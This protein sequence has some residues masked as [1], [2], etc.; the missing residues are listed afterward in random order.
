[1]FSSLTGQRCTTWLD[2]S[3]GGSSS[4]NSSVASQFNSLFKSSFAVGSR[5]TD[6][7]ALQ[8]F[9]KDEGYYFGRVDGKYG[10]ITD[11]AVKDFQDDN[12]ITVIDR[13][14]PITVDSPVI[15]GV[16][17]PQ[18]LNVNQ[19]GTWSVS[20][21]DSNG[22]NLTYAVNWGD[23]YSTDILRGNSV[24]QPPS[25]S[26]TFTH[27]YANTG[28]Y[29]VGFTVTNGNDQSTQTTLSVNVGGSSTQCGLT[30]EVI[31]TY[32]AENNTSW[33]FYVKV[34]NANPPIGS[35]GW[36]TEFQGYTPEVTSY[37]ATKL[38]GNFF[39]S[40]GPLQFTPRDQINS[41]CS[42]TIYVHPPKSVTSSI[43]V[44]SPNGG[45]TFTKNM[46]YKVF[47]TTTNIPSTNNV[48]VRL[49]SI[50]TGQESLTDNVPNTG[51]SGINIP[52]DF[53]DGKYKLEVKT[54][55]NGVSYMD[56]SD[57]SFLITSTTTQ[58]SITVLSPNGGEVWIK[59]TTQTIKWQ[60]NT[61]TPCPGVN[62][63]LVCVIAPP[64][65]D[66]SLNGT[67]SCSGGICTT[68]F[69]V[70]TIA[71]GVDGSSYVWSVGKIIAGQELSQI[72]PDGSYRIQVCKTGTDTCD[73]S[74]SYFTITSGVPTPLSISVLSP[75]GGSS[76]WT[77]NWTVDKASDGT[78]IPD[79]SDYKLQALLTSGWNTLAQDESDAYFSITTQSSNL[80]ITTASS[81]PNGRVGQDYSAD[82]DGSGDVG[83]YNWGFSNFAPG[84]LPPGLS[85]GGGL[86]NGL[87]QYGIAGVPTTVGTY[88]FT[89]ILTSKNMST[90]QQFT[91]T[92]DPALTS[93]LNNLNLS[94]S[95]S[96]ALL[97]AGCTVTS[98]YSITTGKPCR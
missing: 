56:A 82:I 30:A 10:R 71:I 86:R 29:K 39:L 32:L 5:G 18:S 53:A 20:A 79:G 66:I 8:Q 26:A 4:D 19:Q 62:R 95:A 41:N 40:S 49:R 75:N 34:N 46:Q 11:R 48:T 14:I 65:Y 72:V 98:A 70:Y 15:S 68:G 57:D 92:I 73:S 83:P 31:K 81:L 87:P 35:S 58:P 76:Q 22:G 69:P 1:V 61:S 3:G 43:T 51:I 90:G 63:G 94:A 47:W 88:T 44:L 74:D 17:G 21:S 77:Y 97:P 96:S 27:S 23:V 9:L 42:T 50:A 33:G 78:V 38:Y 67:A 80:T 84:S 13:K 12:D 64:T 45:E 91:L 28:V 24:I 25:Q 93:S 6:V 16:S 52:A 7:S 60:D 85:G 89:L 55:I 59:G 36:T 37:G 54:S 2:N